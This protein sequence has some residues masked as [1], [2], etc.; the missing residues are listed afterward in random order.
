MIRYPGTR[1]LISWLALA[2]GLAAVAIHQL[3]GHLSLAKAPPADHGPGMNE[4]LS[5]I[6]DLEVV[7][8]ELPERVIVDHIAE[9]PLFVATRRPYVPEPVLAPTPLPMQV[10]EQPPPPVELVGSMLNQDVWTV[11]LRHHGG[12]LLRLREGQDVEGWTVDHIGNDGLR[13]RQGDRIHWL[14]QELQLS[15]EDVL[16]MKYAGIV[17]LRAELAV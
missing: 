1:G 2:G 7:H 13:L 16:I 15:P 9:R 8:A 10:Q 5:G 12:D 11:L 4:L 3:S 6:A 17:N 14:K